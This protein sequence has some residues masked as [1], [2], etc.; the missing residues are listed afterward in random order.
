MEK[1]VNL[2][3]HCSKRKSSVLRLDMNL[4]K[5]QLDKKPPRSPETC[6]E[7]WSKPGVRTAVEVEGGGA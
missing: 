1:H 5:P 6:K 7:A 3:S 2:L 4:L